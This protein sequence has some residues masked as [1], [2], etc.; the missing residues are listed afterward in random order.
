MKIKVI[1][2]G[3]K[4]PDWV[5][6][7]IEEYTKRLPGNFSLQFIEVP[8][9]RRGKGQDIKQAI[10]KESTALIDR[11]NGKEYVITLE[12]R[13]K[14]MDTLA[15]AKRVESIRLEG[16]DISLLVGGPDG[17]GKDCQRLANESWSLSALTL[18]HPLVRVVLA[19]QIYRVWS[20]LNNHPYHRQ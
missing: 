19:E 14:T 4:M 16:R 13:G 6:A 3:T 9:V 8:L 7:G 1:S 2:V 10:K 18:P 17:L 20:I 12:I 5:G 15:L 11:L